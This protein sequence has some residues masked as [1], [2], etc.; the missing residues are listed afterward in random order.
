MHEST[1]AYIA[2]KE[3]INAYVKETGTTKDAIADRL[4][5]GRSSFYDRLSGRRSWFI[6]E[7]IAL[8][9]MLDCSIDSLL[10]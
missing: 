10:V 7:V 1:S 5:I 2:I 8:S 3:H 9:R 6:D 4:G